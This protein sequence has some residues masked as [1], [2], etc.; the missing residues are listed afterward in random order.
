MWRTTI[1]IASDTGPRAISIHVL[2]VEDDAIE[3][4]TAKLEWLFQSTSSVWRT[5]VSARPPDRESAISIHVLRVEDDS[6]RR[7]YT[8]RTSNF[9]P[10][11][12]C[13]GRPVSVYVVN[14]L[15]DFNPRPPCG[16]RPPRVQIQQRKMQISIH[17]LRVED[18]TR[19]WFSRLRRSLF[20]STSSVWRTTCRA[21][22]IL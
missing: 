9:N 20:Q 2:R 10:R 15:A 8:P 7:F 13:G 4:L 14:Q 11:P 5:T 1:A 16:G 6:T 19:L 21:K 22:V 17:V 12:P 3:A 18:D